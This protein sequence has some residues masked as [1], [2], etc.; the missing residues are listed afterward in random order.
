[1]CFDCNSTG[2]FQEGQCCRYAVRGLCDHYRNHAGHLILFSFRSVVK[3][4]P[5]NGTTS[6]LVTHLVH[7]AQVPHLFGPWGGRFPAALEPRWRSTWTSCD[8]L[9]PRTTDQPGRAAP[10]VSSAAVARTSPTPPPKPRRKTMWPR[11]ASGAL[12][13]LGRMMVT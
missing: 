9:P 2:Q 3:W 13:V 4:Q 5:V 1:M 11:G 7:L 6:V 8:P 12:G 10:W